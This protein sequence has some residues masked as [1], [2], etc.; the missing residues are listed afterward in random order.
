MP[1]KRHG[2]PAADVRTVAELAGLGIDQADMR[3][4]ALVF[5]HRTE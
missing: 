1:V 3:E 5:A 2:Y 4:T